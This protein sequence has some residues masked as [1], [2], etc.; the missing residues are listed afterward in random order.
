MVSY[1][2]DEVTTGEIFRLAAGKTLGRLDL[3]GVEHRK[4]LL[5]ARAEI[6]HLL[7]PAWKCRPQGHCRF[8]AKFQ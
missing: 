4:H 2:V 6:C 5:Q 1:L 7:P 3:M 8:S